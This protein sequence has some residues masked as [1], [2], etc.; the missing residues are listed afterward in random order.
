MP[1]QP[2]RA[3]PPV[4]EPARG[5]L[6][7][8]PALVGLPS[9]IVGSVAFGMVLIGVVP[10]G[11][12]G[13]ALPILLAA[14]V[15]SFVATIW[16]A[17][18]GNSPEAGIFGVIGSFF[19]SYALLVLGL[20]HSWFALLPA[21]VLGTQKVFVIS[22]IVI[23]TMLVLAMLRLPVVYLAIFA[24]VDAAL[25]LDLLSIIQNS[26]NLSKA[27]GWVTL[28]F[29]ALAVYAFLSS[30]SH[31]TGGKEFPMGKPLLRT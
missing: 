20:S 25:V 12:V 24:I 22:W 8:E 30:A 21:A 4:E 15:G 7:G 2:I 1:G 17:R 26:A 6:A 5:P 10:V 11:A 9:F 16:A 14:A 23:I 27:A 19:L 31:A 18:L 3:V 13:A 28:G 29:A